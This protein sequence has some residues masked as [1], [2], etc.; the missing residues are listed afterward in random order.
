MVSVTQKDELE[1]M[2]RQLLASANKGAAAGRLTVKQL[3]EVIRIGGLAAGLAVEMEYRVPVKMYEQCLRGYVDCV[4]RRPGDGEVI[5]AWEIDATNVTHHHVHG[6]LVR[7]PWKRNAV[8][9]IRKL[10]ATSARIKVHALYSFRPSLKLIDRADLVQQWHDK[11]TI[12][13]KQQVRV[14]K[15]SQL[16]AGALM[17]IVNLAADN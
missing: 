16:L 15:D 13:G 6:H 12:L 2:I 8:G 4:W 1:A 14:L 17:Q 9:I 11:K 10:A 3:K 7:P 5:V